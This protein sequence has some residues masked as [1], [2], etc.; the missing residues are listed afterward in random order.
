VNAVPLRLVA[1]AIAI[2]LPRLISDYQKGN[3]YG[4]RISRCLHN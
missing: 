3:R 4:P 2:F 1:A